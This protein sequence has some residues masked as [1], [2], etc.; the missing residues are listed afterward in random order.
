MVNSDDRNANAVV[1]NTVDDA[2]EDAAAHDALPDSDSPAQHLD[3]HCGTR[4]GTPHDPHDAA[5]MLS[6]DEWNVSEWSLLHC[7]SAVG[8]SSKATK[9]SRR[10][11]H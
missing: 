2:L 10:K 6:Q 1:C 11:P 5:H 4:H 8:F 7:L 3:R 9:S